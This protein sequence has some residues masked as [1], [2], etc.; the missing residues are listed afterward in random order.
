MTHDV[1]VA[2]V[3]EAGRGPWAGPVAVG[4]VILDP[5]QPIEG[6]NDSKKLSEKQRDALAPIIKARA[7]SW[8]VVLVSAREIDKINILQATF[9]GMRLAVSQLAIS[10]HSALIDGNRVPPDFPV[11]AEAIIKGDSKILAISAASILAKVARDQYM[12]ELDIKWPGYGFSQHKGYGT[13]Q[14][15]A[16]LL[17]LGPCE[18]HR[19]SF[20]PVRKLL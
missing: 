12:D 13:P 14:H 7:K 2:G 15:Q 20:A 9:K 5:R 1:W 3:D 16:A 6:L 11:D 4:A 18:E 10:P 19:R 17:K 8:S